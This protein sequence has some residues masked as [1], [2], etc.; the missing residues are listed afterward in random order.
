MYITINNIIGEK[1]I[2]L[3]YP[4]K[5]FSSSKEVAVISMLSDNVQYEVRK[6]MGKLKS[7][8][9]TSREIGVLLERENMDLL[10]NN[11][12]TIK[13]N[14]LSKIVYMSLNLNELYN[15]DNLEDGKP[16]NNLFTYHVTGSEDL[17]HL[18]LH[19]PPPPDIRPLILEG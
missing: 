19:T 7:K 5:N 13:I 10:D 4:I 9:Y 15:N 17:M 3:D 18:E 8:F 6:P 1:T 12:Q 14:K 2:N 16:S 11:P